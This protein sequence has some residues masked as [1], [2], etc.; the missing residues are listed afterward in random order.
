M[1]PDIRY[2]RCYQGPLYCDQDSNDHLIS[3]LSFRPGPLYSEALQEEQLS[4]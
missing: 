1:D 3:Y 2:A 4:T